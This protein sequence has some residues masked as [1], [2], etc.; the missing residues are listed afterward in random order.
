MPVQQ[1]HPNC[2]ALLRIDVGAVQPVPAVCHRDRDPGNTNKVRWPRRTAAALAGSVD[3]LKGA[4]EN[5]SP[6][7]LRLFVESKVPT[8]QGA[9]GRRPVHHLL[10]TILHGGSQSSR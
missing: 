3:S 7:S 6:K 4:P 10:I 1:L 2:G 5:S 8:A 9:R